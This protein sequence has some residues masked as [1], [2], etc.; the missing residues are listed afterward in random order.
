M[1][2]RNV[3]DF[4]KALDHGPYAWPGGYPMFFICKDGEALSF[5]AAVENSGLI[6][7]AVIQKDTNSGWN[8]CGFEVNWEDQSLYC[9]HT[10]KKIESAYGDD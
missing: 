5:E 7:D 3:F 1:N 10:N 8:V 9:S 6:R 2:I 4:N